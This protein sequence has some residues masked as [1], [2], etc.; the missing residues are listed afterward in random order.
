MRYLQVTLLRHL[1]V[2]DQL[3]GDLV[4][5]A[6]GETLVVADKPGAIDGD[7]AACRVVEDDHG[8]QGVLTAHIQDRLPD[9]I[10]ELEGLVRFEPEAKHRL[11][12][13]DV[14]SDQ[15][16]GRQRVLVEVMGSG[17]PDGIREAR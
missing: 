3:C 6:Y 1:S 9:G 10:T 7:K 4:D 13:Y 2:F 17:T 15:S 16:D 12:P 8:A 14:V 11:V 5:L